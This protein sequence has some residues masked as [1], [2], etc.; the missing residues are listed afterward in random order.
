MALLAS[1]GLR[2]KKGGQ[3]PSSQQ[4]ATIGMDEESQVVGQK[5]ELLALKKRLVL[6]F[7]Y[8]RNNVSKIQISSPLN[9]SGKDQKQLVNWLMQDEK[10]A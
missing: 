3:I 1:T 7:H 9:G 8:Q 5:L 10:W 6:I 4:C 2:K